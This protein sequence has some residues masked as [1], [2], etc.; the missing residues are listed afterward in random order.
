MLCFSIFN[1]SNHKNVPTIK[2]LNAKYFNIQLQQV[3]INNSS[4]QL[5][6]KQKNIFLFLLCF[7][8]LFSSFFSSFFFSHG[9]DFFSLFFFLFLSP[10][11]LLLSFLL[12]P[13]SQFAIP[14]FYYIVYLVCIMDGIFNNS[15]DHGPL[16]FNFIFKKQYIEI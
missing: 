3:V 14:N 13:T 5:D 9:S 15:K 10:V 12:S 6:C 2:M 7:F 11:L 4:L 8:S 16:K 1:T